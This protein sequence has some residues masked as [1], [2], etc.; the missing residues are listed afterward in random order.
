MKSEF[1]CFRVVIAREGGLGWRDGGHRLK[2]D[3][4]P[5][6]VCL[7]RARAGRVGEPTRFPLGKLVDPERIL[8]NFELPRI[9]FVSCGGHRHG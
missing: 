2:E 8:E 6:R 1:F 4:R 7:D 3:V 5:A 9:L